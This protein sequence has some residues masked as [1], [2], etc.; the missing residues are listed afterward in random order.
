MQQQY[1]TI[2]VNQ[3]TINN[4]RKLKLQDFI[5]NNNKIKFVFLNY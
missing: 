5:F 1:R 4:D 3:L 2:I